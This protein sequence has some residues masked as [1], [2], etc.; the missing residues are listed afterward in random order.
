MMARRILLVVYNPYLSEAADI[1]RD[2]GYNQIVEA[3]STRYALREFKAN[4]PDVVVLDLDIPKFGGFCG[5][6]GLDGLG[7]LKQIKKIDPDVPIVCSEPKDKKIED[8]VHEMGVF[9]FASK[10]TD[11]HWS[12]ISLVL[13]VKDVLGERSRPRSGDKSVPGK[14]IFV[15]SSNPLMRTIVTSSMDIAGYNVIAEASTGK[16]AIELIKR[17]GSGVN[18]LIMEIIL[19]DMYGPD[20]LQEIRGSGSTVP[21][22]MCAPRTSESM[23]LDAIKA[24]AK[25]MVL[26]TADGGWERL[27]KVVKLILG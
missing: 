10:R 12:K 8:K 2:A 21:T 20:A 5:L 22:V 27:T 14:N 16:E 7:L 23:V 11:G 26:M 1:L 19:S 17:L 15:V 25:D 4:K 13:S 18:L 9:N 24:G 6:G 3:P